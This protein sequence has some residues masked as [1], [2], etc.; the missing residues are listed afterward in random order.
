[1][2]AAA[3]LAGLEEDLDIRVVD[4]FDLIAGTSTGGI[5][6]LALG[7]GM[8]PREVLEFYT[9]HGPDIFSNP[10]RFRDLLHWLRAKYSSAPL[11][12]AL[13]QVFGD[14]TFGNS[15]KRLLITSYNL[16]AGGVYLF[17]TPHLPTLTRDWRECAVDVAMATAAAPSYFPGV[18]LGG[19]RLIDGGVVANNPAMIAVIE[20]V[21]PLGI[22]SDFVRLLSV[23][24]TSDIPRR[25]RR[26]D[27]G[28][29]LAWAG[30]AVDVLM[31]AQSEN[32][33][34]QV[35]HLLGADR[36]VRLNANVP[37][38]A[39]KLDKLDSAELIGLAR[40]ESRHQAPAFARTFLDH[41]AAEYSPCHLTVGQT[42]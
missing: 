1:M 25:G 23:G 38:G 35:R 42:A 40:Y 6:A 13:S 30:D 26:L 24:T 18:S 8:S 14:K 10:G 20:A 41:V 5:I 15:S 19:A 32:A 31:R 37:T 4:H 36:V 7:M 12:S 16:N 29:R 28:G 21:G 17:R 39:M 2:F 22:Q 33:T 11:R 34:N 3:V 27:R 9:T